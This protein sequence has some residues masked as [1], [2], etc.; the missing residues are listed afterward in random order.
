MVSRGGTFGGE[1]RCKEV[2][3]VGSA[4][5]EGDLEDED[6]GGNDRRT[7]FAPTPG[8]TATTGSLMDESHRLEDP[9]ST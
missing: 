3:K 9:R 8:I 2:N 1:E 5:G 6:W 7:L 4:D